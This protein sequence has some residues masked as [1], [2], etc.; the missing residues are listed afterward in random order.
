[1]F[2]WFRKKVSHLHVRKDD[3]VWISAQARLPGV[4][5]RAT[6]LAARGE[7]VAIGVYLPGII[8]SLSVPPGV[9]ILEQHQIHA[10][11]IASLARGKAQAHLLLIGVPPAPDS[12]EKLLQACNALPF[13]LHLQTHHALDDPHMTK[14]M[15]PGM[16]EML[17]RL[18][19]KDDE[20]IEH[21]LV[22]RAIQ[23]ARKKLTSSAQ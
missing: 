5:S 7:P 8:R 10:S 2:G 18:G 9:E 3:A 23:N 20:A 19:L 22:S 12:E 13:T 11:R 15:A 21:R 4:V 1:M 16:K 6:A 14:F 17:E